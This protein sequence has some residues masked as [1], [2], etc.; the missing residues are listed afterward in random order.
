MTLR[1][2]ALALLA[3]PGAAWAEA[4]CAPGRLDLRWDGGRESFAVEVADEKG[5]AGALHENL[6][7]E[8]V[9]HLAV[10]DDRW[11]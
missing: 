10:E 3:L 11:G 1:L 7:W 9:E 6:C 5:Q 8:P 4:A 2:A